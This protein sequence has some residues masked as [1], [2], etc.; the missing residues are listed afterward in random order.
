MLPFIRNKFFNDKDQVD[1]EGGEFLLKWK[2]NKQTTPSNIK[3][4][5]L[6]SRYLQHY[7]SLI[8]KT[9]SSTNKSYKRED[10][11]KLLRTLTLTGTSRTA[12]YPP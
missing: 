8:L 7:S 10:V 11:E 2:S 1:K 4:Y 12:L 6:I 9:N 3:P 5:L